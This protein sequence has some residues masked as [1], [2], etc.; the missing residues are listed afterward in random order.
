[1]DGRRSISSSI[2][3]KIAKITTSFPR[4][5]PIIESETENEMTGDFY[6]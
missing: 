3:K 5:F 4:I 6:L 2:I 1:M